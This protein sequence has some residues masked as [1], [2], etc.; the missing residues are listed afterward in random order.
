VRD[1][2]N[3]HDVTEGSR[4]AP[5]HT[6]P[7]VA[8]ADIRTRQSY[9]TLGPPADLQLVQLLSPVSPSR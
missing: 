2:L 1:D 4:Y 6:T 7:L 5:A 8:C 9:R 3:D